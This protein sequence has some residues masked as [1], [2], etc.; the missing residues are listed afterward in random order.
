MSLACPGFSVQ[1]WGSRVRDECVP[2]RPRPSQVLHGHLSSLHLFC[3]PPATA[4]SRLLSRGPLEPQITLRCHSEV[5]VPCQWLCH[6]TSPSLALSAAWSPGLCVRET[7]QGGEGKCNVGSTEKVF[8]EVHAPVTQHGGV[9]AGLP[10]QK[11]HSGNH[12]VTVA[13]F[14]ICATFLLL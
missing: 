9:D 7:K 5:T 12:L 11:P 6:S 4:R 8:S 1:A 3:C 14:S 10:G 13:C 2:I